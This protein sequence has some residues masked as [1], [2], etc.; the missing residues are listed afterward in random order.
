MKIT[1]FKRVFG[2]TSIQVIR[3]TW[4]LT[5]KIITFFG[6]SIEIRNN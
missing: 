1:Y 3:Q 2:I 4:V 5:I 6:C